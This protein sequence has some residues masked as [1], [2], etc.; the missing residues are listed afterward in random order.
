MTA[1]IISSN[2]I[3][4]M[5]AKLSQAVT[6]FWPDSISCLITELFQMSIFCNTNT[7]LG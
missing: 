6:F 4:V 7:F 1:V 2:K 5:S 3:I